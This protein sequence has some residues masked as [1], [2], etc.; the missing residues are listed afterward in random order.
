[1]RRC[2][3]IQGGAADLKQEPDAL[4]GRL[5]FLELALP[6]LLMHRQSSLGCG[7]CNARTPH[8]LAQ[9]SVEVAAARSGAVSQRRFGG[10]HVDLQTAAQ[11]AKH[12]GRNQTQATTTP[13]QSVPGMRFLA[14]DFA[15]YLSRDGED[16]FGLESG[17][18]LQQP[19][20]PLVSPRLRAQIALEERVLDLV[21]VRVR[22]RLAEVQGL[23]AARGQLLTRLVMRTPTP[24]PVVEPAICMY[25]AGTG[26]RLSRRRRWGRRL[27]KQVAGRS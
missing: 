7:V 25:M 4:H 14:F 24:G 3:L 22:K 27:S 20:Q 8:M 17:A 21:H 16:S 19:A 12:P 10:K 26:R 15:L 1:M 18:D 23:R 6:M 9:K 5:F 2:S 11:A 13:A